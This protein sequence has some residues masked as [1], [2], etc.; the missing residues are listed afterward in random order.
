M[1]CELRGEYENVLI[2]ILFYR[3]FMFFN[4]TLCFFN[5]KL[6]IFLK[7]VA[8]SKFLT[9]LPLWQLKFM[10]C[11]VML[12]YVMLCYVMLCCY[13]ILLCCVA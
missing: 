11:Y 12:C 4:L 3:S 1:D 6:R 2:Q 10:L 7:K 9:K 8:Y 5:F 13:A